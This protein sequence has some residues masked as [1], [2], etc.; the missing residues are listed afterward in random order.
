MNDEEAG[1]KGLAEVPGLVDLVKKH[2]QPAAQ[3]LDAACE[4]VLEGLHRSS[5]LAKESSPDGV[6]YGDMLKD[7]F[8]SF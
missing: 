5:L 6:A 2:M 7:M 3:D 1:A 4:L 8:K